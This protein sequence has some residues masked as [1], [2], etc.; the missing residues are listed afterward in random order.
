[1]VAAMG[2]SKAGLAGGIIKGGAEMPNKMP[3][4]YI[5]AAHASEIEYAMGNL[6]DNK[7]YAWTPDD[8]KVSATME[9]YFA[10]FIKT[11]NPN[12]AGLPDWQA[13][14][15]NGVSVYININVN[16]VLE[17]EHNRARYLFLDQDYAKK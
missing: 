7:V 13:N 9:T 16:T 2:D 4:P 8:Y 17:P 6:T 12:G 3:P 1:M 10:N 15:S 14:K 11:G 5:G